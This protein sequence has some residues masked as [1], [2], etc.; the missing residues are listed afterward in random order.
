VKVP[1][2]VE[3]KVPIFIKD[4]HDGGFGGGL[5]FGGHDFGGHDALVGFH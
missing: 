4:H 2:V 1:V 5:G 3:K